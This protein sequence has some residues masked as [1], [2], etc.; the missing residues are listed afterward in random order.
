MSTSRRSYLAMLALLAGAAG[1]AD[2]ADSGPTA[3]AEVTAAAAGAMPGGGNAVAGRAAEQ[4][5]AR[6]M[7]LALADPAFRAYVKGALDR[8]PILEHKLHLQRLLR[9]PD[10]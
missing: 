9:G 7:A 2:R 4:R 1:C 6:R 10:R 8:S 3:P 5:L